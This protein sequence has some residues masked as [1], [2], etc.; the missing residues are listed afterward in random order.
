MV[1]GEGAN[2]TKAPRLVVWGRTR[3]VRI[4]ESE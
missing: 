3:R 1:G 2:V 4:R